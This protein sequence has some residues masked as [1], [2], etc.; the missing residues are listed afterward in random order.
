VRLLSAWSWRER[1]ASGPTSRVAIEVSPEDADREA[2]LQT[3]GALLERLEAPEGRAG[4]LGGFREHG[5]EVQM[6]CGAVAPAEV[7]EA[8]GWAAVCTRS[9][10]HASE[11]LHGD[12]RGAWTV[13]GQ[14]AAVRG[15]GGDESEVVG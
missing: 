5:G 14:A 9:R 3:V 13:D 6:L 15:A 7:R 8:L 11:L 2:L 12:G 1:G 4:G 10:G